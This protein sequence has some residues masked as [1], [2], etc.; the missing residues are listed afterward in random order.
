M[1]GGCD[2]QEAFPADPGARA[3]HSAG[4]AGPAAAP[5]AAPDVPP[6]P[7]PRRPR[8][9]RHPALRAWPQPQG[10]IR[11]PTPSWGAAAGLRLGCA[12]PAA[13]E[14]FGCDP[15]PRATAPFKPDLIY[16]F[17][18]GWSCRRSEDPPPTTPFLSWL[19]AI[20]PGS[21]PGDLGRGASV[22]CYAYL[23]NRGGGRQVHSGSLRRKETGSQIRGSL[24]SGHRVS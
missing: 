18:S 14:N 7:C 15:P 23:F 8:P 19:E 11:Q 4:R 22:P 12:G 1:C 13:A 6:W 3:G 16:L 9:S 21:V 2:A 10:H 17:I 20:P 5:T 24:K